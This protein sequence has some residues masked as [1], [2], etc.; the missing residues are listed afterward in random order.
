DGRLFARP[1]QP[2]AP[3]ARAAASA[4]HRTTPRLSQTQSPR[5]PFARAPF[6]F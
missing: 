6:S 3:G 1:R 2:A 5:R 4:V